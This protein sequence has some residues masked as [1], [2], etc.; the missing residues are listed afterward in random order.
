MF[1]KKSLLGLV[2]LGVCGC[3]QAENWRCAK[4]DCLVIEDKA[5]YCSIDPY[6]LLAGSAFASKSRLEL[7]SGTYPLT[8]RK[9]LSGL[10]I[11]IH[12]RMGHADLE[13]VKGGRVSINRMDPKE[14]NGG[15]AIELL[16]INAPYS[17]NALSLDRF[18]LRTP[19]QPH[20]SFLLGDPKSTRNFFEADRYLYIQVARASPLFPGLSDKTIAFAPCEMSGLPDESFVFKFTDG[21]T[22]RLIVRVINGSNQLGYYI[23]R[24]L[25][26]SGNLAGI[27]FDVRDHYRLAFIGSTRSWAELAIPTF[28]L[29]FADRGKVCGVIFDATQWDTSRAVNGYIAYE[30]TCDERMGVPIELQSVVY[31]KRYVLP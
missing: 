12:T 23:G 29:R 8:D 26:A 11:R 17:G 3:V 10:S 13:P 5:V 19:R 24:L 15:E 20:D 28:V 4:N 7:R 30:M 18:F 6:V 14:E 25:S 22:I 31:P 9:S 16:E 2:I 27:D 1:I 21:S